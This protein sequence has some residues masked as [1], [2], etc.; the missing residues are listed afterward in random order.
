MCLDEA[1]ND[2]VTESDEH[3][4][5]RTGTGCLTERVRAAARSAAVCRTENQN[6][7]GGLPKVATERAGRC[8]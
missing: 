6:Q 4:R 5:A 1:M 7:N 3:A 2:S 8:P